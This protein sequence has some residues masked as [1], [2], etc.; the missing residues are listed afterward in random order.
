MDASYLLTVV[1]GVP[2]VVTP[3]EIDI[4]TAE[5][6][7]AALRDATGG[8]HAV[9]VVDMSGTRFVDSSAVHALLEA[10]QE[11]RR[12]GVELRLVVPADGP[13]PRIM[14]LLGV[15]HFMDSSPTRAEA[16]GRAAPAVAEGR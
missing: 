7:R 1:S 4:T 10:H 11:A 13:V 3:E 16:L 5:Q 14:R 6:L 12:E 15:D 8:G 2:V 9:A